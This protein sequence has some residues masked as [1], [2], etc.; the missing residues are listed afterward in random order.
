VIEIISLLARARGKIFG[1]GGLISLD[2]GRARVAIAR[3]RGKFA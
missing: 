3:T 1:G 2:I